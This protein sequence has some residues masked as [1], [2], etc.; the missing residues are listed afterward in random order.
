MNA[1]KVDNHVS[2]LRI[3][4]NS[5]NSQVSF[6]EF[7]PPILVFVLNTQGL[8]LNAMVTSFVDHCRRIL[9]NYGPRGRIFVNFHGAFVFAQVLAFYE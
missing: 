3:S 5:W 9:K 8:L 2:D 1:V 7:N 4:G 6:K